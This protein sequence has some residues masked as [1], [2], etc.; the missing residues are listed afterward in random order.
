MSG[1]IGEMTDQQSNSMADAK[2]QY[3][4]SKKLNARAGLHKYGR[5]DWYDWLAVLADFSAHDRVLDIGCGT[6]WFWSKVPLGLDV[7]LGDQS[8]GMMAEALARVRGFERFSV[9]GKVCDVCALPFED[10][11]FDK[12]LAIHMLY[13]ANDPRQGVAEIARVL[14]PGGVAVISTNGSNNMQAMYEF[15]HLAVPRQSL[16]RLYSAWRMR[17]RCCRPI[18]TMC[19]LNGSRIN[20]CVPKRMVFARR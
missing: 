2:E 9:A 13:H 12:V 7:M 10:D 11:R 4:D 19:V 14:R 3:R 17:P 5:S 15:G 16:L 8:E 1:G 20:W 18:L 6:G